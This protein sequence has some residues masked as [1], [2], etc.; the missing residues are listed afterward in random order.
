MPAAVDYDLVTFGETMVRLH[1]PGYQRIEQANVLEMSIGGTELNTAAGVARLG[2]KTC[3]VSKLV[4]NALGRFIANKARELGV[5]TTQI[6]WTKEGRVGTYFIEQG[7]HPR[8][9]NVIYDRKNSAITTLAEG[10]IDWR[11]LLGRTRLFHTTGINPALGPNVA[12]ETATAMATAKQVGCKVSFDPNMRFTLWTV[13]EAKR[14]FLALLPHVDILFASADALHLFF[15]ITHA[16]PAEAAREARDRFGLEMVVLGRRESL[17]QMRGA[18]SSMVVAD[19]VYE[20]ERREMEI[21]D[22]IGGGDAFAAGFLYGYL[23]TGSIEQAM[24]YGDA[25]CVYKHTILGD[26]PWIDRAELADFIAGKT[27]GLRR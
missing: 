24:A 16:D 19:R 13:E 17:G 6:V 25:M 5:D 26:L 22:R 7:A 27:A 9:T 21:V 18:W 3:W 14:A 23:T 1:P 11:G 20:S 4:D 10:E 15:D 12:R 2:L 8:P